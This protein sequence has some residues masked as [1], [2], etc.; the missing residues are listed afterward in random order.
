MNSSSDLFRS[1][2][3]AKVFY[4]SS[5][6]GPNSSKTLYLSSTK[7]LKDPISYTLTPKHHDSPLTISFLNIFVLVQLQGLVLS[8]FTF[9]FLGLGS[10]LGFFLAELDLDSIE[11]FNVYI[12]SCVVLGEVLSVG[13]QAHADVLQARDEYDEL[14]VF[15]ID[16]SWILV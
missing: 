7:H 4:F 6:W 13:F 14:V 16:Q 1:C 11:L 5:I 8:Q 10:L 12:D 9:D 3:A 2:M 15:S